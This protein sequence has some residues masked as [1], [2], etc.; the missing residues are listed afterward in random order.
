MTI[1]DSIT[2]VD[3]YVTFIEAVNRMARKCNLSSETLTLMFFFVLARV[4]SPTTLKWSPWSLVKH[5]GLSNEVLTVKSR[6]ETH[7]RQT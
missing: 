4:F 1:L 3:V 6:T 7:F 2:R 5:H